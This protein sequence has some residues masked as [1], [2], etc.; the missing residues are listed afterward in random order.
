MPNWCSNTVRITG[1]NP[2]IEKLKKAIEANEFL[3]HLFP[4]PAELK[5]TTAGPAATTRAEKQARA[6]LT[7]KYGYDNWYDWSINNW[8]T[9]WEVVTDDYNKPEVTE[10][11]EQNEGESEL[12][13]NFETAWSPPIGAY[14]KYLTD[15]EEISIFATYYE[16]GCDFMGVWENGGDSCYQVGD[17]KSDDDFW[18]TDDGRLL[19]DNYGI[20]ESKMEYEQEE[21][22]EDVYRYSKGE[23]VNVKETA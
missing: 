17:Y 14:E 8:G 6:R 23:K 9:K 1:P 12:N 5:G 11:T 7:K 16:P 20:V 22:E 15:N 10:L 18:N 13:F 4:M 3:H 2:K 21:E 19:D